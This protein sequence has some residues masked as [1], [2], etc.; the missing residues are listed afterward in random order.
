MN[1]LSDQVNVKEIEVI[2][3][4]F[5]RVIN[6][7]VLGDVVE[8]GCYIGTT[9]VY[10]S[11]IL[12]ENGDKKR[13][14]VYD[15]FQGLPEKTAEDISPI[16]C[17]FKPGELFVTKKQFIKN[18]VQSKVTIPQIK[19]AWFSDLTEMDIPPKISFAFL[20]GDYYDSIIIPLNIIT[21]KLQVG[22]VVIIDDYSN[23]AL[24]GVSKAVELWMKFH[25]K[26]KIKIEQSLAIIYI[27]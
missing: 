16:G 27:N 10:L 15:S 19:K 18:M 12:M 23:P 2:V 3:R 25:P 6:S 13:L 5:R 24:P 20:D 21:K 26:F 8:F 7:G 22:S 1:L 4:E 9:T 14:F 17:D 11:K